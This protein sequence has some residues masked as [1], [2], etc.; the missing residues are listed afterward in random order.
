[1]QYP[2]V[3]AIEGL[4]GGLGEKGVMHFARSPTEAG[5]KE[6]GEGDSGDGFTV[7]NILFS[8]REF[9]V[10]IYCNDISKQ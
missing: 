6:K 5:E 1:M 8:N 2:K 4:D 7:M 3:N 10:D 9:N